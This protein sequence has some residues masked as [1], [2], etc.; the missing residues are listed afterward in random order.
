MAFDQIA[1]IQISVGAPFIMKVI[2]M[3]MRKMDR[4]REFAI[5][6]HIDQKRADGED[7][8]K[9]PY[10]VVSRLMNDYG[11][12]FRTSDFKRLIILGWLHDV[13]EDT[14]ITLE[15]IEKI[16]GD[17]VASSLDFL[18]RRKRESYKAYGK[19]LLDSANYLVF[20]VKHAD[21]KDN[22]DKVGD[23][24]FSKRKEQALKRRWA[25]LKASIEP[26]ISKYL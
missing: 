19:R 5:E 26:L 22:L 4:A 8:I 17:D 18:T 9:H 6:Q 1:R 15:D 2:T 16:F 25:K 3:H 7:F 12:S 23:G 20:L 24:V 21:L 13:V 10:R 11:Y 14:D